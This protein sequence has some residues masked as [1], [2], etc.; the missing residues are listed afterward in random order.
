MSLNETNNTIKLGMVFQNNLFHF[1]FFLFLNFKKFPTDLV[2]HDSFSVKNSVFRKYSP[3][4][5]EF[6]RKR[7]CVAY[8]NDLNSKYMTTLIY[9]RNKTI[10]A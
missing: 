9:K 5:P 10:T 6:F 8:A 1:F 4:N 2:S 3:K 7:V